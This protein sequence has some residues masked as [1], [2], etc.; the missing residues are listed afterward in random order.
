MPP[1]MLSLAEIHRLWHELYRAAPEAVKEPVSYVFQVLS[2]LSP[3]QLL[4]SWPPPTLYNACALAKLVQQATIKPQATCTER[5]HATHTLPVAGHMRSV[6]SVLVPCGSIV[7][8]CFFVRPLNLDE[9]R[10]APRRASPVNEVEPAAPP[11]RAVAQAAPAP[12]L[13]SSTMLAPSSTPTASM[14]PQAQPVSI[15]P[16]DSYKEEAPAPLPVPTV[17]TTSLTKSCTSCGRSDSPEW[18][19]GPSG[20]KTRRKR[21]KDGTTMTLKATGDPHH[22]PPS[23]GSGGGSRPGA[24]RRGKKE[25]SASALDTSSMGSSD[26]DRRLASVLASMPHDA[27]FGTRPSLA[28]VQGTPM[29][30]VDTYAT[31]ASPSDLAAP[32]SIKSSPTSEVPMSAPLPI[33]TAAGLTA[34]LPIT[35]ASHSLSPAS[36]PSKGRSASTGC[37]SPT[38][39]TLLPNVLSY[40]VAMPVSTSPVSPT[41][42]SGN[43]FSASTLPTVFPTSALPSM[44]VSPVPVAP[45]PSVVVSAQPTPLLPESAAP[46]KAATTTP[47]DSMAAAAALS[48][49]Q[50]PSFPGLSPVATATTSPMVPTSPLSSIPTAEEPLL[51]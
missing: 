29:G 11:I 45:P 19:R 1:G 27:R 48:A 12:S 38:S 46:L 9:A 31:S 23:R 2:T 18:R 43:N 26:F 47:M 50:A 41:S 25:R 33:P 37:I 13:P 4:F 22:V 20:H 6:E 49:L 5:L 16:H 42:P 28:P 8:A 35:A 7:L 36:I 21:N 10:P 14:P 34:T 39:S 3:R 44:P 40:P 51:P 30:Q 15:A 17:T 24:H 32:L